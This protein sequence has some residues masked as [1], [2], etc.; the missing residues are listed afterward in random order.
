MAEFP[1]FGGHS[2]AEKAENDAVGAGHWPRQPG[3]HQ[4]PQTTSWT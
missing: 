4:L 3:G 1:A 2:E